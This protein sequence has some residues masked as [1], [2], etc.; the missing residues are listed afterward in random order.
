MTRD[1]CDCYFSFW[2][3]FCA[4]T[5]L[6][7]QKTKFAKNEKMPRDINLQCIPKVMIR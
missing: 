5:R 1:R 6:T 4:F 2:T 3:I 7:A